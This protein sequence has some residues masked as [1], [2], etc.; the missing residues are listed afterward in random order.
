[1]TN[2]TNLPTPPLTLTIKHRGK[3]GICQPYL[4]Q[5]LPKPTPLPS[6]VDSMAWKEVESLVHT[7]LS[8]CKKE[9]HAQIIRKLKNTHTDNREFTCSKVCKTQ[10]VHSCGLCVYKY[11]RPI[12]Y[13]SVGWGTSIFGCSAHFVSNSFFQRA[14]IDKDTVLRW[15]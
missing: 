11:I 8:L 10:T 9:S 5:T 7:C 2:G 12:A 4:L 13:A 6:E 3:K 14:W 15:V 1:M